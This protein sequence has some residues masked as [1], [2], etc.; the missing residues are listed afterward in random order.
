MWSHPRIS[1]W[2]PTLSARM[3]ARAV[4]LAS[5][6]VWACSAPASAT[7]TVFDPSSDTDLARDGSHFAGADAQHLDKW[8]EWWYFNFHDDL[9]NGWDGIITFY[10]HGDLNL[11]GGAHDVFVGVAIW[12]GGVLRASQVYRLYGVGG[13][14]NYY[15][16]SS[17]KCDVSIQV[18]A[19]DHK[20]TAKY[21]AANDQYDLNISDA[22]GMSLSLTYSRIAKG[23]VPGFVGFAN[24]VWRRLYWVVPMPYADVTGTVTL[25]GGSQFDIDGTG[26]HDHNWGQWDRSDAV[27]DWGECPVPGGSATI[28]F[29]KVDGGN[30]GTV[31]A[32]A[33]V[34]NNGLIAWAE[35]A[36]LDVTY[37]G[38]N[39]VSP[40]NYPAVD[41]IYA[42][43]GGRN[44]D[45]TT[46][47]VHALGFVD[48]GGIIGSGSPYIAEIIASYSGKVY[49]AVNHS[50]VYL[51]ATNNTSKGFLEFKDSNGEGDTSAPNAP[52]ALSATP[53]GCTCMDLSWTAPAGA[54]TDYKIFRSVQ[55]GGPYLYQGH[56][57]GTTF[58]D[59]SCMDGT[60]YYY[61]VSACD[62]VPNEGNQSAQASGVTNTGCPEICFWP[63][64]PDFWGH[65][66]HLD[67]NTTVPG[68][69]VYSGN[70]QVGNLGPQPAY[71]VTAR[72]FYGSPSTGAGAG[73]SWMSASGTAY[74]PVIPPYGTQ[75]AGPFT[76]TVPTVNDFGQPYW[77]VRGTVE[78]SSDPIRTGTPWDDNNVAVLDEWD[79]ETGP[80]DLHFWME[81]SSTEPG[82][83]TLE[84]EY[85]SPGWQVETDPP[86]GV[87]ILLMPGQ[88]LPAM[89]TV[90]PPYSCSE[91]DVRVRQ[92]QADLNGQFVRISGGLTL[93]MV[94]DPGSVGS[95]PAEKAPLA[96]EPF[97]P[98]PSA[99]RLA[100]E[101]T[102]SGAGNAV[103]EVFDICGRR[104]LQFNLGSMGAG[105]HRLDLGT[106]LG[107]GIYLVKLTQGGAST[108]CRAVVVR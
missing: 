13:D 70:L 42:S 18:A 22:A 51:T 56:S 3:F 72:T 76:F 35:D 83:M 96:L 23:F 63:R 57:A 58:R 27:W 49:N 28:V 75:T 71:S 4:A 25:T 46:T 98:N 54:P 53:C 91:G 14:L 85:P 66:T 79:I 78:S 74:I 73:S 61:V 105:L 108:A 90:T 64:P 84:T 9:E 89:L 93:R 37:K 17:T 55:N 16:S 36:D 97:R 60:T 41:R 80:A 7:V 68:L 47:I 6:A 40:A 103:L 48:N 81:N 29:A 67:F 69:V 52:T 95:S 99:G 94:P 20:C 26:Y 106:G 39:G 2:L 10:T 32:I 87:P 104:V 100:V 92:C 30:L 101:C 43:R 86:T 31:G 59:G 1:R 11:N 19:T 5:I 12:N 65:S 24:D 77:M 107:T 21:D 62:G 15:S 102:L 88:R 45:L 8:T 33:A 44:I 82:L 50:T 38:W 34:D